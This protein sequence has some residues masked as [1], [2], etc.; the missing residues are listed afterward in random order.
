M[1]I[2]ILNPE[3]EALIDKKMESGQFRTIEEA[4]LQALKSAPGSESEIVVPA[5]KQN[6][7]E[8]LRESSLWNSGLEIERSK[9][10]PRPVE[11]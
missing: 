4:L 6:F 2:E 9:D 10:G 1:T 7:Y 5:P 11:F 8:F 3:L